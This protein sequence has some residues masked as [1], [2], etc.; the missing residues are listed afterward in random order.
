MFEIN[1]NRKIVG[2]VYSHDNLLVIGD[3]DKVYSCKFI[4]PEGM[5]YVIAET[6]ET[7]RVLRYVIE[8]NNRGDQKNE[9]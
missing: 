7:G 3:E 5:H 2:V 8:L 4:Q 1:D 9:N 6:N